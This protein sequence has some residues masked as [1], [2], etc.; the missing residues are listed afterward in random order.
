MMQENAISLHLFVGFKLLWPQI[1]HQA[2]PQKSY[3]RTLYYEVKV[4][5]LYDKS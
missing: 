1:V 3:N 2:S 5:L 4:W